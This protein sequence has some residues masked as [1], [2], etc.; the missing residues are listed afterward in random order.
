[1]IH[2]QIRSLIKQGGI[3]QIVHGGGIYQSVKLFVANVINLRRTIF[4]SKLSIKN[5][6][7]GA[8]HWKGAGHWRGA[9]HRFIH[10]S[11]VFVEW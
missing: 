6:I 9:G 10:L 11:F 4:I 8:G 2:W 7:G 1:M 5:V 3:L